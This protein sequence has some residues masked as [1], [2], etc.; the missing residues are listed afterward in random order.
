MA[1]IQLSL[2][3]KKCVQLLIVLFFIGSSI[4]GEAQIR[5]ENFRLG[6]NYGSGAQDRFPFDSE[7][8][9]HEV[10]FYKIQV[11]YLL[12]SKRK[13]SFEINI[14]PAYY[15][16]EHQLLNEYFIKESDAENYQELRDL[17][18][19]KRTIK[20]YVLNLGFLTRYTVFKNSSIYILGSVGPMISNKETERLASGFAFS[21]I[22]AFGTSYNINKIRLDFRYSVRHTSNFEIK[23]PNNGHNTTNLE[24]GIQFRL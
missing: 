19:Q 5:K 20:E 2:M 10:G 4:E 21:D 23:D 8:Y 13:W 6:F 3:I 17:Y 9:R 22:L 24:F 7:Q 1:I 16:A 14:E 18:T 12:K 11:N 15:I